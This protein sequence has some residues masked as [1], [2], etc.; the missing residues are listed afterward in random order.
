MSLNFYQTCPTIDQGIAE[1]KDIIEKYLDDLVNDVN[2]EFYSAEKG[3]D[4]NKIVES[5][6]DML[7]NDIEHIFESVRET[8]VKMREVADEQ[9][10]ELE[11]EAE[12]LSCEL[13]DLKIEHEQA[14]KQILDIEIDKED[15]FD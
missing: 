3:K 7:Y 8:N 6:R 4:K 14:E 15:T 13:E 10:R 9:I 1:C 5:V 12:E 2:P 11:Y